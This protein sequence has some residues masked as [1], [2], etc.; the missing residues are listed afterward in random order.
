MK[1]QPRL[2]RAAREAIADPGNARLLSAAAAW[3]LAIKASTGK[4]KLTLPAGRLL[5]E[6]L[7]LNHIELLGTTFGDLERLESLP[8]HH[9]DPFD[10]MMAAQALERGLAIVSSDPIFERYG[11]NRIW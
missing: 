6:Q 3:E 10:R 2:S 7:P 11:I 1:D 8:F 5:A 9:R 4:L